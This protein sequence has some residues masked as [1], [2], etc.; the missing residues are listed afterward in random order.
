MKEQQGDQIDLRSIF[1]KLLKK[2]WLFV[3]CLGITGT[4]AVAHLQTAPRIYL[5]EASMLMKDESSNQTSSKDEFMKGMSLFGSHGEIE[6]QIAIL[7]SRANV[8]KTMKRLDFDIS[9]YVVDDFRTTEKYDYPPFYVKLDSGSMQ[10]IEVPIY[11]EP[12]RNDTGGIGSFRVKAEGK[13]VELYALRTQKVADEYLK[14]FELDTIAVV[15]EKFVANN[16]AFEIEFPED[17][18]YD[19]D[20]YFFK[21]SSLQGLV[22]GYRGSIAVEPLSKESNVIT[23]TT[24]TPVVTKGSNFINKLMET[25]I[26]S[27]LYKRQQKGLKTISFIDGQIG[28]VSDSLRAA[29]DTLQQF[30]S[31]S[32]VVD[33]ETT[34]QDLFERKNKLEDERRQILQRKN[35]YTYIRDYLHDNDDVRNV[36][37]PSSAGIDDPML[38]KLLLDLTDLIV[39]RSSMDA[40][41]SNPQL[42]IIER[43]IANIK[44]NLLENVKGLI[45]QS[46][47]QLAEVNKQLGGIHGQFSKLPENERKL[48]DIQRRFEFSDN[49]YNYLMEKR[50]EAG[51]AIA[52]DQIDKS[53]VDHA[54]KVGKKPVSPDFKTVLGMAFILGLAFPIAFIVLRD[55]LNDRLE[56]LEDLKKNSNIPVLGAIARAKKSKRVLPGQPKT[57]LAESFRTARINLKYL[58]PGAHRRLIG[59][60][61]STSGEGKTFC[62]IN[63]ATVFA[64]GGKRTVVI[65]T[66]MRKPKVAQT[67]DLPNEKGLS[68][69]LVGEASMDEV[70]VSSDIDGLDV[71]PSGPIPPNP[72]DLLESPRFKEMF[73]ALAAKYDHVIVDAAPIGLVSEYWIVMS[74]VDITLYVARQGFTKR[75]LLRTINE[76]Y[77]EEKVTNVNLL[78]ND[79][80]AGDGYGTGYG[81]YE[82]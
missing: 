75:H 74:N 78:L 47:I 32:R 44:T 24:N 43:Q 33:V 70:L 52:S 77:A 40:K 8:E 23:I 11:I 25:Y 54:M 6:D 53:I 12:I 45:S 69:Y 60:T 27:E 39:R 22:D 79:V 73:D 55:M 58:N 48:V 21:T 3:I 57:M 13:N 42:I 35:Y 67:L 34:S 80:K 62:A 76:L 37:A 19:A 20:K 18:T 41:I 46:D 81:Y 68:N 28:N 5:V 31:E 65:D 9:Y 2:W 38:N 82:K 4:L 56:G 51:I 63:L 29:E 10:V 71:I 14:E 15:G 1:N 49:I 50:T 64:M 7:T 61:S 26:E 72:L 66:D 36:V 30:R 16:L 59:V 17:R